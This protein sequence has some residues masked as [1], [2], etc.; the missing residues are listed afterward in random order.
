MEFFSPISWQ[1]CSSLYTERQ[2]LLG[3]VKYFAMWLTVWLSSS[4]AFHCLSWGVEEGIIRAARTAPADAAGGR[5]SSSAKETKGRRGGDK[6]R[7]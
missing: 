2:L 1:S 5:R 7:V 4:K 6:G 3:L